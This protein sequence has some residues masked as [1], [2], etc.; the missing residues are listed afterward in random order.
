[1][2]NDCENMS[3]F[4]LHLCDFAQHKMD[5]LSFTLSRLVLCAYTDVSGHFTL[6]LLSEGQSCH[7]I[8]PLGTRTFLW[9]SGFWWVGYGRK[10]NILSYCL[11]APIVG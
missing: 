3:V 8:Q 11:D 1:M 7:S 5:L 2:K 6:T 10:R 9:V 4:V